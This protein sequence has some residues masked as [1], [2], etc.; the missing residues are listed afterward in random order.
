MGPLLTYIVMHFLQLQFEE[1]QVSRFLVSAEAAGLPFSLCLNKAD[2]VAPEELQARVEQ[3]RCVGMIRYAYAYTR[4][5][6]VAHAPP[7][8][9]GL[10]VPVPQRHSCYVLMPC[11]YEAVFSV[12]L[13]VV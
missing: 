5:L 10:E 11:T 6:Q 1:V 2:L 9:T 12:L 4:W 13:H 3:C 8:S 7:P